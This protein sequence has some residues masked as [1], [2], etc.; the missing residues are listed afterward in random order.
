MTVRREREGVMLAKPFDEKIFSKWSTNGCYT[1]PKINGDRCRIVCTEDGKVTMYSSTGLRILGCPH[2]VREIERMIQGG[3]YELFKT[4]LDGELW[5]PGLAHQEV[6]GIVS[7]KNSLSTGYQVIN[8][9]LF[10]LVDKI[11]SQSQRLE[12]LF[13]L[14]PKL[15]PIRSIICVDTELINNEDVQRKVMEYC[16]EGYEGAI[17]R[18]PYGMYVEGKQSSCLKIK[19]RSED[20]Y[21]IEGFNQEIDKDGYAKN[22]LG[23]FIVRSRTGFPFSVGSGKLLTKANRE[24]LWKVRDMLIGKKIRVLYPELTKSGVPSQPVVYSIDN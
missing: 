21:I 24:G 22:S 9:Y 6:H 3:M 7:R 11:K 2:I 19:P 12:D 1:Q 5:A 8:F 20:L 14:T 16:A 17:L 10:D 13:D 4:P 23:S 18:Y 15:Y